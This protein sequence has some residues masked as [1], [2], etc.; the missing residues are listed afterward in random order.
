MEN[1]KYNI[2]IYIAVGIF[3]LGAIFDLARGFAFSF[4]NNMLMEFF[5]KENLKKLF[6]L[7]DLFQKIAVIVIFFVLLKVIENTEKN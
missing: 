4:E 1:N 3:L 7:S 5:Y 2:Y 6:F